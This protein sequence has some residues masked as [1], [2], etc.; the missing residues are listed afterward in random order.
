VNPGLEVVD[1]IEPSQESSN[2]PSY[3]NPQQS[4]DP[5]QIA[6]G[7]NLSQPPSLSG[8]VISS[9]QI[10]L[11]QRIQAGLIDSQNLI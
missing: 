10:N 1:Q 6:H 8:R 9:R 5:P 11:L 2:E 4:I 7:I 3:L